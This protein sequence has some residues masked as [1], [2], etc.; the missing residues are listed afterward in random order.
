[1]LGMYMHTHWGYNHPY[2]ARTWTLTDWEGYLGGLSAL[3]YDFVMIWPLL[4]S[5]PPLPTASDRAFLERIARA[6]ELAQA[7]F[8]MRVAV[9]VCPNTIG[10]DAASLYTF[11]ERPYFTCEKKVDPKDKAAVAAFLRGRRNQ[12]AYLAQ[13]DA[14]AIIDSDPGG[15]PGSTNDE[16]V[17]LVRGQID[18]FR[19]LNP[20]A[21]LI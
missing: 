19:A 2:A 6:I 20:Q 9:I 1:M 21:E 17:E 3:G 14:L 15:Y 12:L 8:D 13:A 5:M 18:I 16:F 4:D 7:R 10:N 11:Q